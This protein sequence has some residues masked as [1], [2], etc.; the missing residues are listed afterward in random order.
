M[1]NTFQ[2]NF[3]KVIAHNSLFPVN[4]NIWFTVHILIIFIV[5]PVNS[6]SL[7]RLNLVTDALN[8][9]KLVVQY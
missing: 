4:E 3:K 9:H 6:R 2:G 8:I 7:L 5:Y 1:Y